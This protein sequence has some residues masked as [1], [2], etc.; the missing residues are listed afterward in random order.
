MPGQKS[1]G[2]AK[3]DGNSNFLWAG[4]RRFLPAI[5]WPPRLF[6]ETKR[7]ERK[8]FLP[9]LFGF[10]AWFL[11]RAT[12]HGSEWPTKLEIILNYKFRVASQVLEKRLLKPYLPSSL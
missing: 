5:P 7:E 8:R 2:L 6:A 4:F 1:I 12:R 9:A 11:A 3:K 10:G